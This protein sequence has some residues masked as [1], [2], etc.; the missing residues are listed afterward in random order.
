MWQMKGAKLH[1]G[2]A[3]L[4]PHARH[5]SAGRLDKAPKQ[6]PVGFRGVQLSFAR[7]R[8]VHGV[9]PGGEA[10]RRR[11]AGPILAEHEYEAMVLLIC[12]GRHFWRANIHLPTS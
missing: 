5:V 11:G 2:P 7:L 8:G 4:A 9:H 1:R 10:Y 3:R 6:K 12:G